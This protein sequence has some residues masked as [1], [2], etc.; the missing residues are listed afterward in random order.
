MGQAANRNAE[1][2]LEPSLR[3]LCGFAALRDAPRQFELLASTRSSTIFLQSI[4]LRSIV[5]SVSGGQFE[6]NRHDFL[7]SDLKVDPGFAQFQVA[8][9]DWRFA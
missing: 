6:L 7:G 2:V 5:G 8:I 9:G 1:V 3:R 4:F